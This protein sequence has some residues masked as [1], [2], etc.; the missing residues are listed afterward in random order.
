MKFEC[1]LVSACLH[2]ILV[3]GRKSSCDEHILVPS[4]FRAVIYVAL[5]GT[6]FSRHKHRDEMTF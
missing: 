1:A 5:G 4:N 3:P 6:I 2:E